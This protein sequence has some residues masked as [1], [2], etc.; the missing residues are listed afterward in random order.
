MSLTIDCNSLF[1]L[2]RNKL[3]SSVSNKD[4]CSLHRWVLL[5]N[6][7][8]NSPILVSSA[9]SELPDA[10]TQSYSEDDDD[11]NADEVEVLGSVAAHS[12]MFPDAGNFVEDQPSDDAA[13]TSEAQWLDSLLETL[14]D[15]DD[16]DFG[17]DPQLAASAE[18]DDEQLFSPSASPMS[19][20][21]DLPTMQQPSYYPSVPVSYPI[22]YPPYHPP[23]ALPL[24]DYNFDSSFD[25]SIS[26][27]PPP[28]EDPL[29][30]YDS[31]DVDD[32]AVPD[33]IEDISDDESDTP[34]TPSLSGSRSSL[35]PDEAI[36]AAS[37]PLPPE[38][39]TLRH[40]VPR[41]YIDEDS[42]FYPFDPLPFSED[43]HS[44]YNPYQEC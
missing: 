8:I 42:C 27:L 22:P 10:A 44:G 3:H 5:K 25:S 30:Y 34:P 32:L 33:A 2:A 37:I 38:R 21:D 17:S 29:P 26:S 24:L 15:D 9:V 11:E 19:S 14:G 7:I 39:S 35:F 23:L 6:S 20:S 13:R 40:P 43:V 31:D 36:D 12:F 41:V 28:Y 18:D 1:N 16:D 4:K